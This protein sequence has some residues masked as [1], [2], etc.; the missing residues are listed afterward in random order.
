MSP[1]KA[2]RAK[3]T[4]VL[5]SIYGSLSRLVV[6]LSRPILLIAG[7]VSRIRIGSIVSQHYNEFINVTKYKL[8][9]FDSQTLGH[10]RSAV[11]PG[12][13]AFRQCVLQGEQQAKLF[14]LA[15]LL[16]IFVDVVI[17]RLGQH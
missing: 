7:V 15:L 10:N 12:R 16:V 2:I 6:L 17:V 8:R 1:N 11:A 13:H 9:E 3:W 5:D 14:T 4:S